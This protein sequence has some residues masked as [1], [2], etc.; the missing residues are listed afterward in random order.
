MWL[1]R[2]ELWRKC[3]L[4]GQQSGEFA[5]L[6]Q[7]VESGDGFDEA[8]DREG[9]ADSARLA[10]EVEDTAFAGE[11]NGDAH[12]RGDAGAVDLGDAVQ[13]YDHSAAGFLEN[14]LQRRGELIARFTDGEA[15]MHVKNVD[16]VFV[17]YVD[18]DW[19]VLGHGEILGQGS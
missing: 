15:A 11:R 7:G 5:G 12:Q 19:G 6:G 17:A 9:V 4:M 8:S 3:T 1:A 13:V 10:D 2:A 16:A 14:G 18:F